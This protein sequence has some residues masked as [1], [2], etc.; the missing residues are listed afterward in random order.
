MKIAEIFPAEVF[1]S[2]SQAPRALKMPPTFSGR[3]GEA[4]RN[5]I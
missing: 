5:V 2:A 3:R 4:A 1:V